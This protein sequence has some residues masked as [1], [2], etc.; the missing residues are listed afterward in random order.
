VVEWRNNHFETNEGQD[1][2]QAKLQSAKHVNEISQ[3]KIQ[4]VTTTRKETVY[5]LPQAGAACFGA[6]NH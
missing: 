6:R 2:G 1:N 4:G 3:K 5:T